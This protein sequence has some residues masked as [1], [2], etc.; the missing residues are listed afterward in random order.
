MNSLVVFSHLRWNFVYQRPQHILSRLA[1]RWPIVFIEE[2]VPRADADRVEIIDA[3]PGVQVWRPHL[4]GTDPGLHPANRQALQRLIAQAMVEHK[5]RHYWIWFYT[6]MALPI[7]EQLAPEGVIYDCMDELSLFKGAPPQLLDQEAALFRSADVVFTGGRS[8]YNAKRE[9]HPNVHCFPSSVDATHF[10]PKLQ[11]HAL[12]VRLPHPRLGYCGVIDER[13]DLDL[14]AGIATARPHWQVVM[15]GPTAKIDPASLPQRPNIHWLGQQGYDELPAFINGWDVCLLPFALNDS[16]R[17]ISPTKT[18]EYMACGK[19][20]VSTAIR[21]VVEPYGHVVPI[22]ADAAGFVEACESI[23]ARTPQQQVEH[24]QALREIIARTS[25]DLT[26]EAMGDLVAKAEAA[27]KAR[28][29]PAVAS[30]AAELRRAHGTAS[31][32]AVAGS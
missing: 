18:L 19:P 22:R 26:A 7:A 17:F 5:I 6:P 8:L 10:R 25:W 3:A 2:A 23:L 9:R 1:R 15:V 4:R 12:Q 24:A 29:L 13:I 27:R 32:G 21:D 30:I 20:S 16:T 31:L 14:V 11:D 28:R